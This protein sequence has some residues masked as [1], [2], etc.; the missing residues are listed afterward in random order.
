M[1]FLSLL[2]FAFFIVLFILYYVLPEKAQWILLLA[3]S[4]VFYLAL[5]IPA[6]LALALESLIVFVAAKKV[7]EKKGL[8]LVLSL[9]LI[10][11]IIALKAVPVKLISTLGMSYYTLMLIGYLVDVYNETIEPEKN[12]AR[13]L[14]FAGF[15]PAISQG[16]I[17]RYEALASQFRTGH[18]FELQTIKKGLIRFGWGAFKK[19]VIAN[20][21]AAFMAAVGANEK[22][23][24]SIVLLCLILMPLNL[25]ADFSGC[26]D[27]ALGIG[28][29]LGID[30]PENFRQPYFSRSIPEFWRRWHITLSS[31]MK[32]YIYYPVM[33]SKPVKKFIK[34]AGK[35][36]KKS[37]TKLASCAA[38]MI[39]WIFMGL[40]HGTGWKFLFMGIYCGI[41]FILT[42]LLEPV[43]KKFDESHEK[44][45]SNP[46]WKFWQQLRT[47]FLAWFP[48]IMIGVASFTQFINYLGKI[49][50]DFRIKKVFDGGLFKFGLDEIQWILLILG[51]LALL[52][53]SV[54]EYNF[55]E[56]ITDLVAKQKLP[57]RILIYWF[58]ILMIMLSLSVANTEFVYAQF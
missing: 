12:Y 3:G 31:W 24:G 40:W 17:N 39:L 29:M 26:V 25:Y 37:R 50:T 10:V 23:A 53:G 44:L 35:E 5:S 18:K 21:A 19:M 13:L 30:L 46:I 9:I 52:V 57:I 36:K 38:L 28:Q 47:A 43:S 14:L 27:M 33:M 51:F 34:A 32:D 55:R 2:F 45:T 8:V 15:F 16:P 42:Y 7:R 48:T 20:R 58:V 4:L 41:V 22:A 54:I 6:V 11:L 49:F 56:K 1:N